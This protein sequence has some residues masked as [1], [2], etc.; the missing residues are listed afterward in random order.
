VEP[1]YGHSV[2]ARQGIVQALAELTADKWMSL[3]EAVSLCD[4]LMHENARRIFNLEEKYR[5]LKNLDWN[6]I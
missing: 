2:M 1:V 5:I 6:R 3:D 4:T